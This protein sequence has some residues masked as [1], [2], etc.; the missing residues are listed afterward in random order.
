MSTAGLGWRGMSTGAG[1][2]VSGQNARVLLGVLQ[3][4]RNLQGGPWGRSPTGKLVL[5]PEFKGGDQADSLFSGGMS[6]FL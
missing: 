3:R 1:S 6:V 4:N 2:C 5:Q